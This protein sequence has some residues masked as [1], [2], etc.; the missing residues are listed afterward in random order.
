MERF[1]GLAGQNFTKLEMKVVKN[2]PNYP[3]VCFSISKSCPV[4]AQM[5]PTDGPLP[6]KKS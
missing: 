5:S 1:S 4:S 3:T 2:Y 6:K